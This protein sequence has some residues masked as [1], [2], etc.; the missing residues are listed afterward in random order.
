MWQ[1]KIV[2]NKEIKLLKKLTP[3]HKT[4]RED[5]SLNHQV[6]SSLLR[7]ENNDRQ[8]QS[9]RVSIV[10]IRAEF[11]QA[12]LLFREISSLHYDSIT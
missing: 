3:K 8:T 12:T 6:N 1:V 5:L 9:D 2:R 10:P 11:F 4:Q 7:S